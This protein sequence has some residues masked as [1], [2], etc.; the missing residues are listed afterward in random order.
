[1]FT[2]ERVSTCLRRSACAGAALA[3]WTIRPG[4]RRV[5]LLA[6][7]RWL[8]TVVRGFRRTCQFIDPG[9]KCHDPRVLGGDADFGRRQLPEERDDQRI[10]LGMAQGGQVGGDRHPMGRIEPPVTVSSENWRGTWDAVIRLTGRKPAS[11]CS[12]QVSNYKETAEA[13]AMNDCLDLV[14]RA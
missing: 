11:Y 3:G 9:F 14:G 10:F 4:G 1:M 13:V 5:L 2:A 6:L 12:P 8:G 7:G